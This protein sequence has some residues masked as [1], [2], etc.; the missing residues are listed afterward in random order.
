MLDYGCIV[1]QS[2]ATSMLK[3]LDKIQYK[4]LRLL[5]GAIRST[6]TAALQIETWEMPLELRRI[7]QKVNSYFAS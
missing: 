5:T 1:F 7:F 6:L 2:A 4:A 3:E